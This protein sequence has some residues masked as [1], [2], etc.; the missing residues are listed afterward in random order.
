LATR[1]GGSPSRKIYGRGGHCEAIGSIYTPDAYGTNKKAKPGHLVHFFCL[2]CGGILCDRNIERPPY[3]CWQCQPKWKQC[4]KIH[5]VTNVSELIAVAINPDGI[6]GV[7]YPRY[8]SDPLCL[9]FVCGYK[10]DGD[11]RFFQPTQAKN[12]LIFL[13]S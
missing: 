5:L 8:N 7:Y 9:Q 13:R 10:R 11:L 2:K 1:S 6:A 4:G 3:L 12:L